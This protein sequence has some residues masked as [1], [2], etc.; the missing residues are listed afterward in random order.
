MAC[1]WISRR[2]KIPDG[3]ARTIFNMKTATQSSTTPRRTFRNT[4][5]QQPRWSCRT[6]NVVVVFRVAYAAPYQK[7]IDVLLVQRTDRADQE[8]CAL[9]TRS[10]ASV[11]GQSHR[12]FSVLFY[13]FL[14]YLRPMYH[15]VLRQGALLLI[16]LRL[17]HI[18][19]AT[20]GWK[21]PLHDSACVN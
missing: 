16:I 9:L 15:Q 11:V 17:F 21:Y 8:F 20:C 10:P 2:V 12:T 14:R 19:P 5:H 7:C 13:F 3:C 18:L 4:F 1:C 6:L